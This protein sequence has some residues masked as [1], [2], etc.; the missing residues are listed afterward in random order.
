MSQMVKSNKAIQRSPTQN[1]PWTC[2]NNAF[3]TIQVL[4]F[5]TDSKQLDAHGHTSYLSLLPVLKELFL[6]TVAS[7]YLIMLST[8]RR[9][10]LMLWHYIKK[11]QLNQ[12]SDSI[13]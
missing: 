12:I 1:N 7:A 8:L 6:Y 10:V 11:I 5:S 4:I 3:T 9:L 2:T 13:I